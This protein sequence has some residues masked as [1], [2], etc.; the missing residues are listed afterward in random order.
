RHDW[1]S[2]PSMIAVTAKREIDNKVTEEIRY[3]ISSLDANDPER[4]ERGVRAAWGYRE[5]FALGS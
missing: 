4:L 1:K 3:F 5:Q 2:L